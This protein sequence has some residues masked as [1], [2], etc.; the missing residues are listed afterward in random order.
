MRILLGLLLTFLLPAS[1]LTQERIKFP[2]GVSSK[3]LGYGH[4]WAPWKLKYFERQGLDVEVILMR[5]TAPAVQALNSQLLLEACLETI[6][7]WDLQ[8]GERIPLVTTG[9]TAAFAEIVLSAMLAGSTIILLGEGELAA[10][11]TRL[12]RTCAGLEAVEIGASSRVAVDS[13][14]LAVAVEVG[15]EQR[16]VAAGAERGV[17]DGL[18]RA[19]REQLAHLLGEHRNVIRRASLQDVRQHRLRSLRPW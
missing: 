9:G 1:G 8:P 15:G 13:D 12:D 5:G 3:V 17:D 14:Q 10:E 18:A 11:K 4:L 2:V 19:H 7:L 6:T 16:R